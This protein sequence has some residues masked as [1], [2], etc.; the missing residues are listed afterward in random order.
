MHAKATG[1]HG[2]GSPCK[3]P[4]RVQRVRSAIRDD[5][6]AGTGAKLDQ[7]EHCSTLIWRENKDVRSGLWPKLGMA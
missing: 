5:G 7:G 1:G 4:I 6:A 2:I 3:P